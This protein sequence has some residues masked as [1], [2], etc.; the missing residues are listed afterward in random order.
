MWKAPQF[1]F[2]HHQASCAGSAFGLQRRRRG[3]FVEPKPNTISAPSG[4]HILLFG[5]RG[6]SPHRMMSL[7]T[8]LYS[9][10]NR[11]LQ[12]CQPYGLEESVFIMSNPRGNLPVRRSF[13]PVRC[14]SSRCGVHFSRCAVFMAPGRVFFARA[15]VQMTRGGVQTTRA[16]VQTLRAR[17]QTVGARGK[18]ASAPFFL[19]VRSEHPKVRRKYDLCGQIIGQCAENLRQCAGKMLRA[20]VQTFR[21][22]ERWSVWEKTVSARCKPPV[23]GKDSIVRRNFPPCRGN[24]SRSG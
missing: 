11:Y 19:P 4:R 10:C 5:S 23:R 13:Q 8:E 6:R 16:H 12:R 24:T 22:A 14:F 20:R 15:A 2:R 9:F 3:I 17:V 7:L 18:S 1:D 21:A